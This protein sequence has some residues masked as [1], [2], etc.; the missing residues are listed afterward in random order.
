M[1][2]QVAQAAQVARRAAEVEVERVRRECAALRHEIG[3]LPSTSNPDPNP[4]PNPNPTLT[5]TRP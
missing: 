1:A 3:Y 5:L 4:E 2:S